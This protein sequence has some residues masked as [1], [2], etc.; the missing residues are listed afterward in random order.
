[1]AHAVV[2]WAPA[3]GKYVEWLKADFWLQVVSV[4][5]WHVSQVVTNPVWLTGV[6]APL[7]SRTWQP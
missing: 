1:M 3:S 7:K 2:A 4:F 6:V 5:L